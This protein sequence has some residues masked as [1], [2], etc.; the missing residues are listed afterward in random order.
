MT[1]AFDFTVFDGTV[2]DADSQTDHAFDATSFDGDGFDTGDT[3]EASNSAGWRFPNPRRKTREEIE[4]ERERLGIIPPAVRAIVKKQA[5]RSVEKAREK[6]A[7]SIELAPTSAE[8]MIA[9]VGPVS[10]GR[11]LGIWLALDEVRRG[12]EMKLE[13]ARQRIAWQAWYENELQLEIERLIQEQ[14]D[15]EDE[16]IVTLLFQRYMH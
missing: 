2:F 11:D 13:L 4:E 6:A 1:S 5:K 8:Q 3:T 12:Q 14:Q 10:I 16:Q 7:R 9:A 15:R